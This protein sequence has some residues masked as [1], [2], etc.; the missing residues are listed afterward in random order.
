MDAP[1]I[2]STLALT[3]GAAWCSG[4][5]LYATVAVLGLMHTYTGFDLPAEMAVVAHPLVMWT[6]IILYAV[7]FVADKIPA[8]DSAWDSVH[9]FI[10]VPAGAVLAAMALGDVPTELQ[11]VALL[12]GGGLAFGAHATKASLRLAAHGTGT[13]PIASPVLSTVEDTVVVGT[14][15]LIA[16]NPVLALAV[17]ALLMIGAYFV[18]VGLWRLCRGTWRAI[19]GTPAEVPAEG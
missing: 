17:L 18:L 8:V 15:A 4:I 12:I 16:T 9:T 2:L 11:L 1:T 14:V 13:S 5:N 7:E 19:R 3:L 10:R 6:A